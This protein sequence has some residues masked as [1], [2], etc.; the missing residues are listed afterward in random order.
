LWEAEADRS[1]REYEAALRRGAL[2]TADEQ[3]HWSEPTRLAHAVGRARGLIPATRE[4]IAQARQAVAAS[5]DLR[6]ASAANRL[7]RR[8]RN[9]ED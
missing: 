8:A 6:Y 7:S 3:P 5:R 2:A 9:A 1:R 4:L